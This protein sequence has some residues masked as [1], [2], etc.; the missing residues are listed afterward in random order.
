[1]NFKMFDTLISEYVGAYNVVLPAI[2][3]FML[4]TIYSKMLKKSEKEGS[5]VSVH[6]KPSTVDRIPKPDA[7]F[8]KQVRD[9]RDL[10]PSRSVC[11]TD[12]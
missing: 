1:M 12:T 2:E 11:V 4:S 6:V 5:T 3:I 9:I 8:V 7:T 10:R